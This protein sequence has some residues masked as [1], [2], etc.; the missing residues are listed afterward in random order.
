MGRPLNK[1]YF[2]NRNIG[3]DGN[4]G[5]SNTLGDAGIGGTGVASVTLGTLG[6]YTTRPTITFAVPS[7]AA[8]IR[9]TGT[10]NSEVLS[11]S[12]GGTQTRAYPSAAGE[13]GFG[14]NG[15]TF[16]ATVWSATLSSVANS[17]SVAISFTTTT[18]A[19]ISGTS[20]VIS[21]SGA[22]NL[23]IG[24][25]ALAAGQ[26]YYMG[27]P[28]TA[29]TATLYDTYANAVAG[30][31]TGKLAIGG[32]TTTGF[33]F[34]F[35]TT[36]GTVQS[37]TPV[38]R[39]SYT[40][41]VTG[42]QTAVTF[43]TVNV[44]SGAGLTITPT[45][46]AL[47]VTITKAGDGYTGVE[48]NPTFTQSV[49]GTAVLVVAN[50]TL[51]V[52]TSGDRQPAIIAYAWVSGSRVEVDIVKQEASR[53]YAVRTATLV[54]GEPWSV[55]SAILV[56]KN[57]SADGEMDITAV[58][59]DGNAYWVTKLTA[60]KALLTRKVSGSGIYATGQTA[61]WKLNAASGIYVKIANA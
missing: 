61:P 37:L 54:S 51:P 6:S 29:T 52:G 8:G 19:N 40:S 57:S 10:V 22:G 47:S 34:T 3:L 50:P 44:N 14:T 17:A 33:T 59:V 12:I 30:G 38:N 45:Y 16:T 26:T 7:D 53:R 4:F 21:G 41:L 35:G 31:S 25:V 9:A 15:S 56:G 24:G 11:A 36:Y 27:A 48:S 39:G 2:G 32:S 49:T 60:H 46:R 18:T 42:A 20:V 58:D 1:K 13:I 28:T 5:A 55:R 43:D 23:T